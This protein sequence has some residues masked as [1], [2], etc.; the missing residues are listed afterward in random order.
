[1]A[2]KGSQAV[3]DAEPSLNLISLS[4][5][6]ESSADRLRIAFVETA[7]GNPSFMSTEQV[8][9]VVSS[10]TASEHPLTLPAASL[11]RA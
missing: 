8:G 6:P 11:N 3:Q 2:A 9:G 4:P 10:M 1:M 7:N 5:L